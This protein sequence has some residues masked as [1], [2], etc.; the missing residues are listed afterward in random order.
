[1]WIVRIQCEGQIRGEQDVEELLN[2]SCF[3]L[4][5][6]QWE[7]AVLQDIPLEKVGIAGRAVRLFL[8]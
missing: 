7:E 4:R 2:R 8:R 5:V 6:Y 1:M 3:T